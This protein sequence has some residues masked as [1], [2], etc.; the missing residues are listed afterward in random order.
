MKDIKITISEES[1]RR[2]QDYPDKPRQ[3]WGKRNTPEFY[4]HVLQMAMDSDSFKLREAQSQIRRL[5]LVVSSQEEQ[6][7]RLEFRLKQQ[8]K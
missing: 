7:R 6:I 8:K 4:G 1:Y 2:L 5:E 3:Q